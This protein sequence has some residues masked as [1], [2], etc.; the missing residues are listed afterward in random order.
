MQSENSR[1]SARTNRARRRPRRRPIAAVVVTCAFLF[2]WAL[3]IGA[4]VKATRNNTLTYNHARLTAFRATP[5]V[6]SVE[7]GGFFQITVVETDPTK[8]SYTISAL[9][10]DQLEKV[11]TSVELKPVESSATGRASVTMRHDRGIYRYRVRI[12]RIDGEETPVSSARPTTP[13]PTF[14]PPP[15]LHRRRGFKPR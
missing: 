13:A 11:G 4:A 8:F 7:D 6:L 10:N 1:S 2:A 9:R 15:D 14:P 3:P 5:Y 12:A